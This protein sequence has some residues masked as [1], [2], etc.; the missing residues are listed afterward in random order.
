MQAVTNALVG[1]LESFCEKL[2]IQEAFGDV[3]CCFYYYV[4]PEE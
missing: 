4:F 2:N 3:S 1:Y